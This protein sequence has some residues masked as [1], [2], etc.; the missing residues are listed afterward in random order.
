MKGL[1]FL[2]S[3]LRVLE[4]CSEDIGLRGVFV[5]QIGSHLCEGESQ[6]FAGSCDGI[7]VLV[8]ASGVLWV[9][10]IEIFEVV[11]LPI[12]LECQLIKPKKIVDLL[13]DIRL[14]IRDIAGKGIIV[15]L[16]DRGIFFVADDVVSSFGEEVPEECP[17]GIDALSRNP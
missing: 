17:C 12:F 8:G 15:T 10:A 13:R 14:A 1:K 9:D 4:I 2:I 7:G 5:R 16:D 6:D 3:C 11:D